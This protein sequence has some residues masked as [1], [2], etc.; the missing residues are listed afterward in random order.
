MRIKFINKVCESGRMDLKTIRTD[1]LV[2]E[3][4]AGIDAAK[5]THDNYTHGLRLYCDFTGLTPTELLEE[6]EAE[7]MGGVLMRKRKI[8][9]YLINF[10][11]KLKERSLAP[12]TIANIM[13][14]VNSFYRY[15]DVDLPNL[16]NRKQFSPKPLKK[17]SLW[18]KKEDIQAILTHAGVRDR[19]IILV[20]VSSGLAQSDVLA[21]RIKD[22]KDGF[23]P[24]TGITT[25]SVRRIKTQY[26][27]TTFLSP[28][29]G[30]AVRD[31]IELRNQKHEK[32]RIRS[33]NDYLFI[34]NDVP[35]SYLETYD[36]SLRVLDKYGL[37]G[38]FRRLSVA[39]GRET[40]K[41]TWSLVRAHNLRKYFNSAL[42]NNGADIFFTDYLMGHKIE[43]THEA[44]FMVD[45][46]KLRKKYMR[47]LPFLSIEDT[48]VKM[49]ES[50]EYMELK[51]E[52]DALKQE[53]TE[54]QPFD[55]IIDDLMDDNEFLALL[56]KKI[57]ERGIK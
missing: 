23:D 44:Y 29:A 13:T 48:Q 52:L 43:A 25:L 1:T 38:V 41:G 3:W 39:T 11:Q 20:M 31:W 22:V 9:G 30:R 7:I 46:V 50:P 24:D 4:M 36:D 17:N 2:Q 34:K 28:E 15:N 54:R 35:D 19:A 57:R 32:S 16:N 42:L 6:A 27:F 37:M 8:K 26:D 33:D 40:E 18:I 56:Q 14:G 49:I 45:P 12:K 5:S 53:K 21:M 47:Y 51:T 55:G 10:R